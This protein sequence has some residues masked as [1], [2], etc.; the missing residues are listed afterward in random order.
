MREV[1]RRGVTID[2]CPECRGVWLDRG[3][4]DRLLGNVERWE[5]ED[6]AY[7]EYREYDHDR[8]D[9][10]RHD[11]YPHKRKKKSIWR[12]LFDFDLFD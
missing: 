4:L 7:D 12:E 5:R 2:V 6:D 11:P 9:A 1:Q 3:E 10:R 8:H